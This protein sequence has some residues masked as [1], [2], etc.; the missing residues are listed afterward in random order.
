MTSLGLA[1]RM[2]CGLLLLSACNDVSLDRGA[3]RASEPGTSRDDRG[4]STGARTDHGTLVSTGS[5]RV[6]GGCPPTGV[7]EHA[8]CVCE[9]LKDVGVLTVRGGAGGPGSVGVNG[10]VRMVN[11]SKI[12]GDFIAYERFGA[13]QAAS[14]RGELLTTGDA[15]WTGALHVG[16]DFSVGGDARGI[17]LLTVDGAL[18]VAGNTGFIG[19]SGAA[20]DAYVAPAGPPCPCDPATFFDVAA[21]VEAARTQNDNGTID[22]GGKL[23]QIGVRQVTLPSGSYY[24]EDADTIGVLKFDIT[25]K[26][27]LFVDGH[28]DSVGI[29]HFH[30]DADAELDL[31]VSGG[32]RSVGVTAAG[33][34]GAASRLRIYV[35]GEDSVLL[36]VG[37]QVFFGAIYA[38]QAQVAYVGATHIEGS[39]FARSLHGVG[40][41]DIED[42]TR[43]GDRD[44]CEPEDE[45]DAGVPGDGDGDDTGDGDGD[46][47]GDAEEP[48]EDP[49]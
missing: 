17:G 20:Q 14:V 5:T 46:G 1:R 29:E 21:A 23:Q 39:L 16:G 4:P 48:V 33:D 10:A 27:A 35:G 28:V 44:S 15:N 45:P 32:I 34:P 41:L 42:A 8:L 47:D 25:G 9:E 7:F 43:E 11:A 6:G 31:Y 18:R 22:L 49:L 26:V 30:L 12:E 19:L 36:S 38:P 3:D 2:A 40:V 13:V 24:I 37:A